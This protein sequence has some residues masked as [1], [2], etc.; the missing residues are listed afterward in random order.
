[1]IAVSRA[2]ALLPGLLLAVAAQAGPEVR[3]DPQLP[4]NAAPL[5]QAVAT[6]APPDAAFLRLWQYRDFILSPGQQTAISGFRIRILKPEALALGNITLAWHVDLQD[7]VLHRLIIHRDGASIDLLNKVEINK[8]ARGGDTAATVLDGQQFATMQVPGLAV[9]DEL[10]MLTSLTSHQPALGRHVAGGHVEP[11]LGLPGVISLHASWP[12][13][14]PLNLRVGPELGGAALPASGGRAGWATRLVDAPASRGPDGAPPRFQVKGLV[15]YSDFADWAEVSAHFFP[16]Y[17]DAARLADG[18]P[19]K[20]EAARI[21]AASPDPLARTMAALALVQDR[22]R[23][24]FVGLGDGNLMPASADESWQRR[25]ADCKGK[26]VLLL[27]LLGELGIPAEAVLVNSGGGD[28]INQ[29][30]PSPAWFDH[31]LVRASVGGKSLW[32][33]GTRQGDSDPTLLPPPRSAWVL[34][35]SPAGTALQPLRP[36]PARL[37]LDLTVYD[38]DSRAGTDKPARISITQIY[39]EQTAEQLRQGLSILAPAEAETQLKAFWRQR[40]KDMTVEKVAWHTAQPGRALVL[41]V[42]GTMTLE[43]DRDARSGST[44]FSLFGG[45]FYPPDKRERPPEQDQA[46]PWAIEFPRFGCDAV[47]MRLPPP[48]TGEAWRLDSQPMNRVL[49]G[50]RYYRAVGL[51]GDTV[52]LVRA[53]QTLTPEISAAEARATN[54]AIAGFDNNQAVVVLAHQRAAAATPLPFGDSVDWT[55]ATTPC[56]PAGR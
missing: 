52:R 8:V 5:P 13:S 25:F 45:G 7:M 32:L 47:T 9:G 39:R 28:G 6:P 16:L 10:E 56:M 34:P 12:Q 24:V 41:E 17:R 54:A 33:D 3:R 22:V 40:M 46:A 43:W 50:K 55:A 49:D 42:S 14:L 21:A 20:A 15:E 4:A 18:S 35:I 29:R 23:Y 51:A 27:A 19:L 2:A 26:T 37:P 30:L 38:I 36:E 48:R 1:M 53:S 44:S 11:L 31:V